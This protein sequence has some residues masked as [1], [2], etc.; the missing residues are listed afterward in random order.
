MRARARERKVVGARERAG[1]PARVEQELLAGGTYVDFTWALALNPLP[2][3]RTRLLV[4]T[5]ANYAPP[6]LRLLALP[7]GIFDATYGVAMLRAIARRAETI[8]AADMPRRAE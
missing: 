2:G 5:R 4:R 7:L 3:D 1:S 8:D 6:A